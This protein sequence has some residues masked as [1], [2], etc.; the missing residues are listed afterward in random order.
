MESMHHHNL[1]HQS[2]RNV[3][4]Q[5][6]S[7]SSGLI[8]LSQ[9]YLSRSSSVLASV[10]KIPSPFLEQSFRLLHRTIE[11]GQ[12]L[13]ASIIH[14]KQTKQTHHCTWSLPI[15]IACK[16]LLGVLPVKHSPEQHNGLVEVGFQGQPDR[17][18]ALP[19]YSFWIQSG[20]TP[21]S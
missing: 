7:A 21:I 8:F 13:F 18:F 5:I 12:A 6:S 9:Q 15:S 17:S 11:S 10:T 1:D 2:D 4:G 3:K 20:A 14:P 19:M 16:H